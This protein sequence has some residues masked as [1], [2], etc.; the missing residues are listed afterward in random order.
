LAYLHPN[1][2]KP[3]RERIQHLLNTY[4][5]YF[6]LRFSNFGAYHD[7][8]IKGIS[9][10]LAMKIVK[11]LSN[12]G[13]VYITSEREL[14][15][16]LEKYRICINP[17]Y[18]HDAIYYSD[19]YIGDSQTM[20]IE[21]AV[22]GIPSIRFNDFAES[23]SV[24]VLDEIENKYGLTYGINRSKPNVLLQRINNILKTSNI[25][26]KYRERRDRM[27]SEKIDVTSFFVWLIEQY[28]E[29]IKIIKDN[30]EYEKN[31]V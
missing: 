7:F 24:T 5:R 15:P 28:P 6:I 16:K 2:F 12:Y 21:S 30:P 22:L 3:S 1:W 20:A 10:Q 29:S 8:G 27:L 17:L 13:K 26:S 4:E 31:F 9:N 19:M 11:I 18:I 25:K 14:D 23:Y